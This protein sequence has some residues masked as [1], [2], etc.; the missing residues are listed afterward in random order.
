MGDNY[1]SY[2]KNWAD[3][4]GLSLCHHE[5]EELTFFTLI[6]INSHGEN[7]KRFSV[8]KLVKLVKPI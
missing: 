8:L 4:I 6:T 1:A 2:I 5:G 3:E 7:L